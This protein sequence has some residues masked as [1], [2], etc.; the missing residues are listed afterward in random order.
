MKQG[1]H[2]FQLGVCS[3]DERRTIL[4]YNL[5]IMMTLKITQL[6]LV[7]VNA[8]DFAVGNHYHTMK[9]EREELFIAQGDGFIFKWREG[10]D[11]VKSRTMNANDGVIVYPGTT[12][13]FVARGPGATL[14]GLSNTNYDARHDVPDKLV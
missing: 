7:V 13:T 8:I 6:K 2:F 14:I 9:S 12:H 4:E 11:E 10:G 1:V 3:V 5:P